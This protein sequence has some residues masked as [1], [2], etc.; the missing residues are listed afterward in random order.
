FHPPP[1]IPGG[2]SVTL[3][4]PCR[5]EM[6]PPIPPRARVRAAPFPTAVVRSPTGG[7]VCSRAGADISR[8]G[9]RRGGCHRHRAPKLFTHQTG[10]EL[11]MTHLSDVFSAALIGTALLAVGCGKAPQAFAPPPPT[12]TVADV[13]EREVADWDEFIGRLEAVDAVDVRA[14]VS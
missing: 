14:R 7:G 4:A 6:A 5:A 9:G 2:V 3:R 13:E 11:A 10:T 1:L 8:P 12:V